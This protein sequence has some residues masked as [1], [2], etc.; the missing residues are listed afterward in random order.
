MVNNLSARYYKKQG[1]TTGYEGYQHFSEEEKGEERFVCER[2]WNCPENEKQIKLVQYQKKI[3][4][5]RWKMFHDNFQRIYDV[6]SFLS[7][8]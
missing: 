7:F 6:I 5:K 1:G 2:Y 8:D 4:T 3:F